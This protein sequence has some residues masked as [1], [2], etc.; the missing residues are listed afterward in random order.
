MPRTWPST[1]LHAHPQT[2]LCTPSPSP[3]LAH[4]HP[5]FPRREVDDI[6]LY[7]HNNDHSSH[8]KWMRQP[9]SYLPGYYPGTCNS[10]W[11]YS[12][13]PNSMANPGYNWEDLG[14][15]ST[16]ARH[17][18]PLG[19]L[20]PPHPDTSTPTPICLLPNPLRTCCLLLI[21]IEPLASD[22]SVVKITFPV[23][24]TKLRVGHLYAF[25]NMLSSCNASSAVSWRAYIRPRHRTTRD[26][27]PTCIMMAYGVSCVCVCV[28]AGP[29]C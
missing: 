12:R 11:Q 13:P 9:T 1:P 14:E 4:T 15:N 19:L 7:A 2:L 20:L 23:E 16:L 26:L 27:Q 6:H 29:R 17:R 8:H 3:T 24:K 22:G 28:C 10:C 5:P 21:R 25:Y 18:P